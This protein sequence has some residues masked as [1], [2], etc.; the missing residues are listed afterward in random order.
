MRPAPRA[1]FGSGPSS[2][3]LLLACSAVVL[4]LFV[5]LSMLASNGGIITMRTILRAACSQQLPLD[6]VI[7]AGLTI[8]DPDLLRARAADMHEEERAA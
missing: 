7:Q 1:S 8:R 5:S 2:E 6:D 3:R 4:L